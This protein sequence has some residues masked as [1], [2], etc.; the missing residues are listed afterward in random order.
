MIL[1][2]RKDG[3]PIEE[4]KRGMVASHAFVLCCRC[5]GAIRANG[6][7]IYEAVCKE[8]YDK[9]YRYNEN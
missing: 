1:G 4:I 2:Y 3:T 8:C 6:G 9:G 5:N 7:P